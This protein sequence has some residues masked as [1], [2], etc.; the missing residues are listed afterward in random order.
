MMI[1]LGGKFKRWWSLTPGKEH[2]SRVFENRALTGI[3]GPQEEEMSVTGRCKKE[4]HN[5]Y[6]SPNIITMLNARETRRARRHVTHKRIIG[7]V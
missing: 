2:G 3:F 6:P 5:R 1:F 4:L 7:N